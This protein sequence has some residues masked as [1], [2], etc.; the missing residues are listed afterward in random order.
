MLGGGAELGVGAFDPEG[1]LQLAAKGAAATD[2]T[3]VGL[4]YFRQP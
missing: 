3:K 4:V 1:N 2:Q